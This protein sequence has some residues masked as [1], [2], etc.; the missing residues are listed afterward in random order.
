MSTP[1]A[2]ARAAAPAPA[3]G[4]RLLVPMVNPP[5]TDLQLVFGDLPTSIDASASAP[6]PERLAPALE[7]ERTAPKVSIVCF[8]CKKSAKVHAKIAAGNNPLCW[9]CH[10]KSSCSASGGSVSGGSAAPLT[11]LCKDCGVPSSKSYCE[12]DLA[13]RKAEDSQRKDALTVPNFRS[14]VSSLVDLVDNRKISL[15]HFHKSILENAQSCS[16]SVS[17]E[18]FDLLKACAN[19]E[20]EGHLKRRGQLLACFRLDLATKP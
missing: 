5:Q 3:S 1:F 12:K 20:N 9:S 6:E 14:A 2:A 16:L 7:P 11:K 17:V 18:F 10:D 4:F 8:G 15:D 19:P 13:R